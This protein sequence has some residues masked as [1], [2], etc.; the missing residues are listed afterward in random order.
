MTQENTIGITGG[1]GSGKSI[2]SR[3][4]RCNGF[5]VYDCDYEAKLIMVCNVVVKDALV[6]E[7]GEDIYFHNGELNRNKLAQQIFSNPK[8]RKKI[9][10]IVHKAVREDIYKRRKVTRG[11]FFI[12]SAIIA[13]GGIAPVCDVIWIV[14]APEE[15]R[16]KRV[17]KRDGMD[18]VSVKKRI[19]SQ[20]HEL[21][22]L[23]S[24]PKVFFENDH[25]TPLLS[26]ILKMTDKLNNQQI[27]SISC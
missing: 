10:R 2:V 13:T 1:I 3:V 11:P 22:L 8:D 21:F 17:M 5:Q 19:D 18:M 9:N 27:Y 6:R 4:L 20:Y 23:D 15:E 26:E 12:E 14:V 24:K 25:K 16:I 7:F